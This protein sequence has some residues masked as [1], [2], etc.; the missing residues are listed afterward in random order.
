MRRL[1]YIYTDSRHPRDLWWVNE[2][3]APAASQLDLEGLPD[4]VVEIRS[5]STWARDLAVKLPAYEAAGVVEAWYVD[6]EAHTV[7]VFRRSGPDA[8]TFEV[9]TEVGPDEELTSPLLPGFTLAV[10]LIFTG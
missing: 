8:R 2:H 9:T 4:L 3:R 7:L 5:A 1:R 6:I 10:R